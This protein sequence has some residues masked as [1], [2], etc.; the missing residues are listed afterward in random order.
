[1]K[2]QGVGLSHV[3]SAIN[4]KA[5][6]RDA[7]R[8]TGRSIMFDLLNQNA[9]HRRSRGSSSEMREG[10]TSTEVCLP[11]PIRQYFLRVGSILIVALFAA[12]WLLAAPVAQA[13]QRSPFN[14]FA[15]MEGSQVTPTA[16][17]DKASAIRAKPR[18]HGLRMTSAA[19]PTDQELT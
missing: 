9:I 5:I 16:T 2:P 14:A 10:F 17:N 15:A 8:T 11:M 19:N 3:S 13:D 12:D 1:M 18:L 6:A 7:K 4:D